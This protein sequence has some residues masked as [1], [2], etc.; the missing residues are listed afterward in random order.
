MTERKTCPTC[1]GEK[2][3][4]ALVRVTERILVGKEEDE[5]ASR[6]RCE[7]RLM[8][9]FRCNGEGEVDARTESWQAQGQALRKK[10]Q[11]NDRSLREE[12]KRLGISVYELSRME[13]GIIQP[14]D[15]ETQRKLI[16]EEITDA[17]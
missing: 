3:F 14:V 9:C 15:Y 1:K 6:A 5:L 17:N 12:A 11:V 2:Q 8:P 7:E 16:E 13:Q 10:R 4:W